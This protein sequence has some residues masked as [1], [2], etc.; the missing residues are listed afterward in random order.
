VP[1]HLG[2]GAAVSLEA[3]HTL[4]CQHCGPQDGHHHGKNQPQDERPAPWCGWLAR[5]KL[6]KPSYQIFHV[7]THKSYLQ[8]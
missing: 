5:E 1:P 4:Y 6:T 2:P 7:V 8:M 3:R